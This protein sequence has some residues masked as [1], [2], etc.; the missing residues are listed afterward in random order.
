MWL[1]RKATKCETQAVV[2][3]ELSPGVAPNSIVPCQPV[4]RISK[5][6]VLVLP[7]VS[8][9]KRR[10]RG[11]AA[12]RA[13]SRRPASAPRIPDQDEGSKSSVAHGGVLETVTRGNSGINYLQMGGDGEEGGGSG[14]ARRL[15]YLSMGAGLQEA[16]RTCPTPFTN[17]QEDT[18]EEPSTKRSSYLDM[19]TVPADDD[20]TS[21]EDPGT[22]R[23]SYMDMADL[24]ESELAETESDDTRPSRTRLSYV[25][26]APMT[27]DSDADDLDAILEDDR[28][29]FVRGSLARTSSHLSGISGGYFSRNDSQRCSGKSPRSS[30][31][32]QK[33]R[34]PQTSPT[35]ARRGETVSYANV[36]LPESSGRGEGATGGA[37]PPPPSH[38]YTNVMPAAY[39]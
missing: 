15:N 30:N 38:N 28:A 5:G 37:H 17:I 2:T 39:V 33:R 14:P 32:S 24:A 8:R 25:E 4:P 11:A 6:D 27:D 16:A 22:K 31:R 23:T 35:A 13:R 3:T 21:T 10:P 34:T 19:A 36:R 7:V 1:E 29:S 9:L 26:M 18:S 12:F 20:E